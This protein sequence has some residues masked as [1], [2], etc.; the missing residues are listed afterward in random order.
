ML[1]I[2]GRISHM[3]LIGHQQWITGLVELDAAGIGRRFAVEQAI[4]R[5][6]A[7]CK[8]L[9]IEQERDQV[10]SSRQVAVQIEASPGLIEI[11]CKDLAI[12]AKVGRGGGISGYV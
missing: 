11:A 5:H 6:R 3:Q 12:R 1:L 8:L 9:I 7:I 2:E 10:P 4:A